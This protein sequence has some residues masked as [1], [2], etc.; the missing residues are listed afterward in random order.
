MIDKRLRY[1]VFDPDR[2]GN[3]RYYVRMPG[4]KKVRIRE[5]FEDKN[6]CITEEFMAAYFAAVKGVDQKPR[7]V[8]TRD[9]FDWLVK[10]Y[11]ASGEFQELDPGT[12]RSKRRILERFCETAGDLPYKAYRRADVIKSRDKRR[13]TP[14]AADNLVKALSRLFNWG[15][16]NTLCFHNPADRVPRIWNS[17]GHHTWEDFE[18]EQF[19]RHFPVGSMPRLALEVMINVGARRSDAAQLGR[20]HE[21]DGWL[22]FKVHKNRKKG[23]I[24]V[25]V[26]IRSELRQAIDATATGDLSYIVTAHGKPFTIAGF[27]SAFKDWCIEAGLPHCSAH[28][29]RKAAAVELAENGVTAPELCAIFGWTKLE[30]AQRYIEKANKRRMAGNAYARLDDYRERKSVPLSKDSINGETKKGKINGKTKA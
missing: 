2:H 13:K 5:T 3:P 21:R 28:G 11:F 20:Q 10:E 1:L 22:R 24:V 27:G 9:T 23:P 14:G 19:R 30:T 7:K 4:R 6:G 26:P 18:V 17:E 29:L 8:A 12:Q 16:D 25:E 15:I